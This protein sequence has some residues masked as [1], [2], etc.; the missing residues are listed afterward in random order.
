MARHKVAAST[1]ASVNGPVKARTARPPLTRSNVVISRASTVGCRWG[2]EPRSMRTPSR[3]PGT[4]DPTAVARTMASPRGPSRR[5]RTSTPSRPARLGGGPQC[6]R[7]AFVQ[8]QS[9]HGVAHYVLSHH[10]P[11]VTG[12][13]VV[14][15]SPRCPPAPSASLTARVAL[16][17]E[18]R[19]PA[20]SSFS[21]GKRPSNSISAPWA[22]LRRSASCC[23]CDSS[24]MSR[25]Y[26]SDCQRPSAPASDRDVPRVH[27]E[28]RH[29]RP[30]WSMR[31][32]T[33]ASCRTA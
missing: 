5:K 8:E 9:L 33:S 22:S 20:T 10:P 2:C 23:C 31:P 19:A 26:D 12:R 32:F 16:S 25:W 17:H 13:P 4:H 29:R 7:V 21:P 14:G 18:R 6:T 28:C 11:S 15:V 30:A 24:A 27:R 3:T 1:V